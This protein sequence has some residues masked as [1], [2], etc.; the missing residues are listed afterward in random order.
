MTNNNGSGSIKEI[1]FDN[2][3][4]LFR[5]T[6]GEL[7]FRDEAIFKNAL[8]VDGDMMSGEVDIHSHDYS[9]VMSFYDGFVSLWLNGNWDAGAIQF[10][11]YPKLSYETIMTLMDHDIEI[12]YRPQALAAHVQYDMAAVLRKQTIANIISND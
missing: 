7:F 10:N 4:N 2:F 8:I 9:K 1:I 5:Y 12:L 6:N 3:P 11:T